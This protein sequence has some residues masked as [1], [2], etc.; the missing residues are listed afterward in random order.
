MDIIVPGYVETMN[1][2]RCTLNKKTQGHKI[3]PKMVKALNLN[4]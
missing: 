1:A 4:N 2:Q 3:M